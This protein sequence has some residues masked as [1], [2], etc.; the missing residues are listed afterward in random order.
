LVGSFEGDGDGDGAV[1]DGAAEPSQDGFAGDGAVFVVVTQ[2]GVQGVGQ[3]VLG[4]GGQQ[5][6]GQL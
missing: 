1:G 4:V 2:V 3:V 6:Q 5:P